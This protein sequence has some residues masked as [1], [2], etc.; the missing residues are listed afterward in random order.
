MGEMERSSTLTAP[1]T[2]TSKEHSYALFNGGCMIS[3]SMQSWASM[4]S[5][6]T[7]CSPKSPRGTAAGMPL[8]PPRLPMLRDSG[9]FGKQLQMA[10]VIFQ[11]VS[12]YDEEDTD[13]EDGETETE[14]HISAPATRIQKTARG[15]R[16]QRE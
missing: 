4:Q 12:R 16:G 6:T 15:Q 11:I 1:D 10:G 2:A 7:K 14:S 3:A 5:C 8:P 13:Q 9:R